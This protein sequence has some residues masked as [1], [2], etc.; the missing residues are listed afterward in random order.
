MNT[1]IC[2]NYKIGILSI[3]LLFSCW[4]LG[5]KEKFPLPKFNEVQINYNHT[6][7]IFDN[8]GKPGFGFGFNHSF[9]K[10][11]IWNPVVGVGYSYISVDVD[12]VYISHFSSYSDINFNL[13]FLT[14]S[15]SNRFVF[16]NKIKEF[17]ELGYFLDF[18]LVNHN[19][20]TY[21][22]Y[23]PDQSYV[24]KKVTNEIDINGLSRGFQMAAGMLYPVKNHLWMLKVEFKNGQDLYENGSV[25]SLYTRICLGYGWK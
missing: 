10:P 14:F 4:L 15:L 18:N 7:I 6:A 3:Q 8:S 11:K 16:G 22:S 25:P 13:H 1:G 5:Q 24:T 2:M 21:H 23:Y 19:T 12:G 20:A 9:R 17:I